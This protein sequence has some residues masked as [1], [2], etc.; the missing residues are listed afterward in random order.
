MLT[1]KT[2]LRMNFRWLSLKRYLFVLT[3]P[4]SALVQPEPLDD[5][6]CGPL[7]AISAADCNGAL[8]SGDADSASGILDNDRVLGTVDAF[9]SDLC[10]WLVLRLFTVSCS[11]FITSGKPLVHKIQKVI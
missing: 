10:S 1:R 7:D 5:S 6:C 3:F 11:V 8:G 2:L 4:S 9:C